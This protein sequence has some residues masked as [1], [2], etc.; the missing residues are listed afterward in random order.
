MKTLKFN[1]VIKSLLLACIVLLVSVASAQPVNYM[2]MKKNGK[3]QRY[4]FIEGQQITY[5][6]N[7][8]IGYMTDYI[9][10]ITDSTLEFST[11][12]VPFSNIES[13]RINKKKHFLL[14]NEYALTYGINIGL[15]AAILETAYIVNS[16]AG[17]YRM[18]TQLTFLSTP[19]PFILLSNLIYGWF[20]KTEYSISTNEYQ[21]YPIVL[22]KE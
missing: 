8:D 7:V 2:I 20:V 22:R 14:K 13:V 1:S 10:R 15:S 19:I 16:G 4:T 18:G 6:I 17:V 12:S 5:K 11:Y 21:L 9:F 3:K